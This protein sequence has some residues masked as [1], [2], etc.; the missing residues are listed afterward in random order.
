MVFLTT[1]NFA[2]IL[3]VTY[4]REK[5][6]AP[7]E[8]FMAKFY[9][10]TKDFPDGGKPLGRQRSFFIKTGNSHSGGYVAEGGNYYDYTAPTGLEAYVVAKEIAYSLKMTTLM[11][12]SG[13]GEGMMVQMDIVDEEVKSTTQDLM[14][15]L[16]RATLTNSNNRLA[17]LEATVA[18]SNTFTAALPQSGFMFR[19][20]MLIDFYTASTPGETGKKVAFFNPQ[21]R[22][23]T[24]AS[25]VTVN[26]T[27]GDHIY[28]SGSYGQGI[29]GLRAIVDDGTDSETTIFGITRSG[30]PQVNATL[31]SGSGGYQSYS[32]ALVRN[33]CI[34]AKMRVGVAPDAMWCNDGI[35]SAHVASLTGNRLFTVS[36][37]EGVPNY[38]AGANVA[39]SGIEYD[40]KMLGW[41]I[42]NDLPAE[43]LY[44]I[45]TPY[46]RRHVLKPPNWWGDGVGPEGTPT[47]QFLQS[48]ASTGQ[49]Y[50][51]AKIAG[52]N[53]FF[54]M[55]NRQPASCVRITN[56]ADPNFSGL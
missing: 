9:D 35:F 44:L 29:F 10:K 43:E 42:D 37:G 52:Q 39:N 32:E 38:K 2:N 1:S 27:A 3:T 13:Q 45:H 31:L 23:V 51:S 34:A 50:A 55:A 30:N 36:V 22:L 19:M 17:V 6:I 26:A 54:N 53:T 41:N 7:H 28:Q 49:G 48:P 8:R 11:Q 15:G 46:F 47:P 40:G 21:T 5:F 56:I 14:L 24:L 25:G 33:G 16:N 12:L 20:N 18:T 4:S